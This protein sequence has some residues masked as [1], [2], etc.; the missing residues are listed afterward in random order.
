MEFPTQGFTPTPMVWA[1][2]D[3]ECMEM[4]QFMEGPMD[5]L[6]KFKLK[7]QLSTLNQLCIT[8]NPPF[9]QLHQFTLM[10]FQE[11]PLVLQFMNNINTLFPHLRSTINQL[12]ILNQS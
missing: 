6:S 12:L 2:S 9:R 4:V 7:H 5:I 8:H 1:L 11:P 10:E 3:M